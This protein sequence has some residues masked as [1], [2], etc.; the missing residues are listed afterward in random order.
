MQEGIAVSEPTF[1]PSPRAAPTARAPW[2]ARRPAGLRRPRGRAVHHAQ[3]LARGDGRRA[4]ADRAVHDGPAIG[5]DTE[6]AAPLSLDGGVAEAEAELG[7]LLPGG[8]LGRLDVRT[9]EEAAAAAAA[10]AHTRA[11]SAAA[12][13]RSPAWASTPKSSSRRMELQ[14]MSKEHTLRD[15]DVGSG[16]GAKRER[17]NSQF[18]WRGHTPAPSNAELTAPIYRETAHE[19]ASLTLSGRLSLSAALERDS[20]PRISQRRSGGTYAPAKTAEAQPTRIKVHKARRT[21]V[22][23][24]GTTL[25][26][27]L[28]DCPASGERPHF[29]QACR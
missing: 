21:R 12:H 14:S 27:Q 8:E 7:A 25:Q 13:G 28:R 20:P 22:C 3:A 10:V 6:D 9:A 1:E 24:A 5:G 23:L 2:A 26:Q 19:V 4:A 18:S 17:S 15:G 29:Q 11:V 16:A